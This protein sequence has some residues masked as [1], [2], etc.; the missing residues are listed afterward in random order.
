[1]RLERQPANPDSRTWISH[2]NISGKAKDKQI[3]LTN[4]LQRRSSWTDSK[5][6]EKAYQINSMSSWPVH[7][8]AQL[9]Q[10]RSLE[11]R[12]KRENK[13]KQADQ[14]RNA[15]GQSNRLQTKTDDLN[16]N[17]GIH[18]R[19][20]IKHRRDNL[21]KENEIRT[22]EKERIELTRTLRKD[23]KDSNSTQQV[24]RSNPQ[25]PRFPDYMEQQIALEIGD[26]LPQP[27]YLFN[28]K[29]AMLINTIISPLRINFKQDSSSNLNITY[30]PAALANNNQLSFFEQQVIN[31]MNMIQQHLQ[32]P[33]LNENTIQLNCSQM[34]YQ[35]R[36]VDHQEEEDLEKQIYFLQDE[37]D[38]LQLR[39][40]QDLHDTVFGDVNCSSDLN[41]KDMDK[42]SQKENAKQAK[43]PISKLNEKMK[44][45]K[46]DIQNM[47]ENSA[48]AKVPQIKG[49]KKKNHKKMD[50][51]SQSDD[52]LEVGTTRVKKKRGRHKKGKNSRNLKSG[53]VLFQ[54]KPKVMKERKQTP[55][56]SNVLQDNHTSHQTQLMRAL[57]TSKLIRTGLNVG[58]GMSNHLTLCRMHFSFGSI[59]SQLSLL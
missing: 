44:Q 17:G 8:Q 48:K 47:N 5:E 28:I 41:N 52:F 19:S 33:T 1:M 42:L 34:Q 40:E 4:G 54:S 58:N 10:V 26:P 20:Q 27:I 39:F 31:N 22:S 18:I 29:D 32:P 2:V 7:F 30:P 11:R 49:K 36:E 12:K 57:L 6:E 25:N 45:T 37:R 51:Q 3:F 56:K 15:G 9:E 43:D 23:Y 24:D 16:R 38:L 21:D 50:K 35:I 46:M 13:L 55:N 59:S 53:I 14:F